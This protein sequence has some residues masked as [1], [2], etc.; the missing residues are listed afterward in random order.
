MFSPDK[1]DVIVYLSSNG[2]SN[3][4]QT[5]KRDEGGDASRNTFRVSGLPTSIVKDTLNVYVSTHVPASVT[6]VSVYEGLND[7]LGLHSEKP[8][9][10]LNIVEG[11]S[12]VRQE[13]GSLLFQDSQQ[14]VL[15][16][17]DNNL[18]TVNKLNISAVNLTYA[19]RV[20]KRLDADQTSISIILDKAVQ[21]KNIQTDSLRIM[22]DITRLVSYVTHVIELSDRLD[23]GT[24]E[25]HF[26]I[27]DKSVLP[28]ITNDVSLTLVESQRG[29]EEVQDRQ[30]EAPETFAPYRAS[31]RTTTTSVPVPPKSFSQNREQRRRL[32]SRVTLRKDVFTRIPMG[33]IKKMQQFKV[34][35]MKDALGFS[36]GGY[37]DYREELHSMNAKLEWAKDDDFLFSGDVKF[38]VQRDGVAVPLT[39]VHSRLD[40]W[41]PGAKLWLSFPLGSMMASRRV[42]HK[43][44]NKKDGRKVKTYRI[45]IVTTQLETTK[46]EVLNV[47]FL[48]NLGQTVSRVKFIGKLTGLPLTDNVQEALNAGDEI[49]VSRLDRAAR[50]DTDGTMEPFTDPE[51][52]LIQRGVWQLKTEV[53]PYSINKVSDRKNVSISY[54]FYEITI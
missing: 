34:I 23:E 28:Q 30:S 27:S 5:L 54:L 42:L 45:D 46:A 16:K 13:Q 17:D 35:F 32:E 14:M 33:A 18:V 29:E 40:A 24:I 50:S 21:L 8:I 26:N 47:E 43:I 9:V 31:V 48:E 44:K 39:D 53:R 22:Y 10:T 15:K 36:F 6:S 52:N 4:T 1:T 37:D 38:N 19:T 51:T 25:S 49:E 12:S 41:K 11:L 7:Q 2:K 3:F 20:L